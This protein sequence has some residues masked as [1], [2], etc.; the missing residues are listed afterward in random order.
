M[1]QPG[2]TAIAGATYDPAS[3]TSPFDS[4]S[5]QINE[6]GASIATV[7]ELSL[8]LENGL[9]PLFV[10]GSDTAECVSIARSNL[11]GSITTFFDSVALYEKFLNET[12]SNLEFT[13]SDGTNAYTFSLPRV[14][15]N[16]G[17]PDVSGE[18]EVTVSMGFQ[19]LFNAT[20]ESQIVIMRGAA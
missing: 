10:V 8:T 20:E 16:S 1:T 18:G 4:F 11:T 17:Q 19:A 6:G 15:Y 5:G 12:E 13:L 14:K 2:Q 9:S 7:T 3:T